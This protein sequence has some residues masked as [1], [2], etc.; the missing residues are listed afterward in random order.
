[1]S[2]I[3][4]ISI[5]GSSSAPR[6]M[7]RP[8]RP[9]PLMATLTDIASSAR[10]L[11]KVRAGLAVGFNVDNFCT[12]E[13]HEDGPGG[14]MTVNPVLGFAAVLVEFPDFL[15][16]S[17]H[18]RQDHVVIHSHECRVIFD[19]LLKLRRERI[20]PVNSGGSFACKIEERREVVFQLVGSQ[21]RNVASK[22]Q[23]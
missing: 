4:T 12:T 15:V 20:D 7:L 9:K 23:N 13:S 3:A 8:M 19:G 11:K 14:R 17:A 6:N 2:L 18:R 10:M 21:V 1:M 5:D 22:V 16:R